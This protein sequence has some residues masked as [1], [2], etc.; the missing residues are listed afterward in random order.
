LKKKSIIFHIPQSCAFGVDLLVM[1]DWRK[2]KTSYF[3]RHSPFY[4]NLPVQV[5]ATERFGYL[6]DV[7][8][9][10]DKLFDCTYLQ[11][12]LLL[13]VPIINL[14]RHV[15]LVCSALT[16]CSSIRRHLTEEKKT[17]LKYVKN[18]TKNIWSVCGS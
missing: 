18:K 3:E 8:I 16:G 2:V 10:F 4:F 5:H 15:N 6:I 11:Q 14:T 9:I 1:D 12:W 17:K 7:R 13:M